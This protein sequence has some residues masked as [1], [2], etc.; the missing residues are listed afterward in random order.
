MNSHSFALRKLWISAF[1]T[2]L[3][4]V[5]QRNVMYWNIFNIFGINNI[6]LAL[7]H[8]FYTVS[9]CWCRN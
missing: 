8:R 4:G 3:S 5:E 9:N 7:R 6:L 1:M 2:E